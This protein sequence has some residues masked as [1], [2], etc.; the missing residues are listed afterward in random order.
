M[1]LVR[2]YIAVSIDGYIAAADGGVDWLAPYPAEQFGFDDFIATIGT[3]VMGRKT[4][5]QA[6]GFEAWPYAGKR[7]IVLTSRPLDPPHPEVE[8]RAG[9]IDALC[10]A[11]KTES[12]GD[13]W[14]VG[15]SSVT[16]QFLDAGRV[17]RI[18]LYVIPILLGSGIRLFMDSPTAQSARLRDATSLAGGVVRLIYDLRA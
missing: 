12:R 3:V 1:P 13:I 2:L 7:T 15:G 11:L 18:E 16:R 4:Y 9:G 17:D 14:L 5:D 6:R 8:T 10:D